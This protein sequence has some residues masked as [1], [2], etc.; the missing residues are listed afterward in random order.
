MYGSFWCPHCEHQKELFGE[1]VELLPYVECDPD[2][3]DSQAELCQ[4]K[5]IQGYPTWEIDGEFYVG[6]RSLE[7]LAQLSDFTASE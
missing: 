1:A 7:E 2:G 3:V 5:E 6:G 4:E